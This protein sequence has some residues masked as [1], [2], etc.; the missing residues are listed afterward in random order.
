MNLHLER[1]LDQG[2]AALRLELSAAQRTA[3]LA[4]VALL[5]KWNKAFNLTA[6]RDPA[7]M[8]TRHLLDSLAVLP[9][10]HGGRIIDIGSGAGLP[11]IPLAIAAPER[12]FTLLDSNGKKTRFMTQACVEVGVGN[13][14]VVNSRVEDF[15]PD[16]LFDTVTAR[17]FAPLASI[18][19][20]T[21]HLLAPAGCVLAMKGA[22]AAEELAELPT[23]ERVEVIPLKVPGLEQEQRHLVR[24]EPGV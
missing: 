4:Y 19:A 23:G 15:R 17:A 5:V 24:I 13:A 7:Q 14:T 3:L 18:V 16:G 12:Q 10:L 20:Q 21:R 2:L 9:H 6:V 1:R 11:G 8:V 22:V